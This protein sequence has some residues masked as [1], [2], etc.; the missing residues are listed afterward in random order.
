[1]SLS[2]TLSEDQRLLKDSARGFCQQNAPISAMRTLR[3]TKD[4]NG[5]SKELWRQMIDMGWAGMAIPEDYGG[6]QFGYVGLGLL[7]EETGRN[8]VCSP[9]ISSVLLSAT[10]ITQMGS[11]EQK[12]ALLPKLVAGELLMA[13]AVDEKPQH[14]PHRI[15]V[16]AVK[17]AQGY[18]LSGQKT[19]VLDGHIADKLI[20]VARTSGASDSV[21]G[22]SLFLVGSDQ[23][24]VKITRT[25]MVDCRNAARVN[26]DKVDVTEGALLGEQDKGFD[27]LNKVLDI[28]RIGLAAEMLGS[29]E[30]AFEHIITYL[31]QREQ[32]GVLIGSFQGL[33]HRAA[34]MYSEIELCRS[35]VRAATAALDDPGKTA[36]QISQFASIAKSKLSETFFLVSNEAVQMHG[37]IGMTDEFDI[38]FYL[39]RARVAQQFLGDACF[40]RDRFATSHNF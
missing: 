29:I 24:G 21:E 12:S 19:F 26:L 38:G 30:Q 28:A 6:Y 4:E 31:K 15:A 9:L 8:L 2:L 34:A 18:Q 27:G 17:T 10:A 1:M 25:L 23:P 39:K 33:Q 16:S 36:E 11:S 5:Y 37:G 32:F 3:D 7:L 35:V 40:H 20:V 13:L 14:A 22:I